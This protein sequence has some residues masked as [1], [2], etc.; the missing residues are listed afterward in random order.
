MKELIKYILRNDL[1]TVLEGRKSLWSDEELK[2]E[3]LKYKTKEEFRNT[4]KSAY[5]AAYNKGKEF[6]N[7]ITSHQVHK[8]KWNEDSLKNEALKYNSLTDFRNANKSAYQLAQNKGMDFFNKITSHMDRRRDK[9]TDDELIQDA[10]KYNDIGTY[11]KNSTGDGAARTRG[12]D[13]YK[14]ISQF[15]K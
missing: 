3:A 4:N 9:W 10:L 5:S 15:Y 14:K 2:Q 12:N 11:I 8:T 13:F 6:F 1:K 7:S